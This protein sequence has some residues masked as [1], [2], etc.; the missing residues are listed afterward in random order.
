MRAEPVPLETWEELFRSQ[1]MQNP[2]PR[3]RMLD[4]FN[5]GWI[6]FHDGG[7]HALKGRIEAAEV[8]AGLVARG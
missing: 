6:E 7:R 1:G 4:G 2:V 5:E 3:I 8:I